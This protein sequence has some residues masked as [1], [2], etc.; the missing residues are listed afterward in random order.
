MNAAI[1]EFSQRNV[2]EAVLS[3][4][5]KAAGIPR[6]SI[7]QY[8]DTKDD[9]YVYVFETLREQRRQYVEP[10]YEF[11]K[12]SP[13]LNFFGEFYLRDS[14]YLLQHPAHIDLGKIMYSHARGVSVSLIHSVQRRY[15]DTFLIGIAYDQD[16]D[17]IRKDVD[18]NIVADLCTHFMT[19]VFIFQNL[20][21]R[22]SLSGVEQH[23]KGVI[24]VL[25][26]GVE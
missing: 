22:M 15:R 10:A 13:F 3:N 11:Y 4:I 24:D 17:R 6:G 26:R 12:T 25:R 9:L 5:V 14:R 16:N 20:T 8:F 7:Y 21:E 23:L 18:A 19:D 2:E 1:A